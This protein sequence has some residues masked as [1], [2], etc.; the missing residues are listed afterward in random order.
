M[1]RHVFQRERLARGQ[2]HLPLTQDEDDLFFTV[3]DRV[4]TAVIPNSNVAACVTLALSSCF[5]GT[6]L[7][8]VAQANERQDDS[9]ANGRDYFHR[10][11]PLANCYFSRQRHFSDAGLGAQ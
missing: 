5:V 6:A 3:I 11:G 8:G 7:R 9:A 4:I 1:V 2:D 10:A